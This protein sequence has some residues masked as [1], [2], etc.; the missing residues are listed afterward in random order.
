[1]TKS[2]LRVM[3]QVWREFNIIRARDG[4]PRDFNGRRT[5]VTQEYWDS[6]MR[7][8]ARILKSH[9]GHGPHC[10][11]LLYNKIENEPKGPDEDSNQ[12]SESGQ[13]SSSQRK[14]P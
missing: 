11:P 3:A 10:H 13:G 2:E 7:K 1:M 9:T 5:S 6:L 12:E 14:T 4:I 8:M